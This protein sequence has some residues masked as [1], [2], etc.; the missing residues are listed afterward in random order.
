M[1]H[2]PPTLLRL[3][4][5]VTEVIILGAAV[6]P[7][8]GR[9]L[10]LPEPSPSAAQVSSEFFEKTLKSI[11]FSQQ[12]KCAENTILWHVCGCSH[13]LDIAFSARAARQARW[14]F[15]SLDI[16]VAQYL[17]LFGKS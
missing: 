5:L 1:E 10:L 16:S 15:T 7:E 13:L 11:S 8:L 17:V 9:V 14:Y 6:S 2:R 4:V 3:K 12:Y